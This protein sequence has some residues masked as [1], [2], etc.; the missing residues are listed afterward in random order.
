MSK[1]KKSAVKPK[2]SKGSLR[3]TDR[4]REYARKRVQNPRRSKRAVA[5]ESGYALQTANRA[6]R[7]IE[8][9]EGVQALLKQFGLT[10]DL[11]ITSLKDDIEAKPANRLGELRLAADIRGLTG[12]DRGQSNTINIAVIK[13]RY[14]E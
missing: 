6:G 13:D 10:D 4:Q 8:T 12:K 9:S 7:D 2:T 3:I 5:L 11:I 1:D 14:A